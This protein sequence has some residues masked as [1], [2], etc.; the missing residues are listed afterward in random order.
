MARLLIAEAAPVTLIH[1]SVGAVHAAF[2]Q[3]ALSWRRLAQCTLHPVL[4][5]GT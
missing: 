3:P 5:G 1:A 2:T 4:E